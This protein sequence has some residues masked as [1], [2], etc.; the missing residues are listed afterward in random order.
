MEFVAGSLER[1]AHATKVVC[2]SVGVPCAECSTLGERVIVAINTWAASSSRHVTSHH[3]TSHRYPTQPNTQA[4]LRQIASSYDLPCTFPLGS[5]FFQPSKTQAREE[6]QRQSP[7]GK[8][9]G[10]QTSTGRHQPGDTACQSNKYT[11]HDRN[12]SGRLES[13]HACCS[14]RAV[15]CIT[16]ACMNACRDKHLRKSRRCSGAYFCSAE[17]TLRLVS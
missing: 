8:Q 9:P 1:I 12:I 10:K 3:I 4:P 16:A 15:A 2:R 11:T 17:V 7:P 14:N 6:I 13:C 5:Q